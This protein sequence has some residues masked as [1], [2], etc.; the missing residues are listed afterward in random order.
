MVYNVIQP[1]LMRL[2]SYN[3]FNS[4]FKGITKDEKKTRMNRCNIESGRLRVSQHDV[5]T[6][7]LRCHQI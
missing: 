7:S 3:P 2:Q 1:K 4:N 5:K 6:K